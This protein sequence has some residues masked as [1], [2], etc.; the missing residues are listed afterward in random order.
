[1]CSNYQG[2]DGCDCTGGSVL[3]VCACERGYHCPVCRRDPDEDVAPEPRLL[4]EILSP[5]LM[6]SS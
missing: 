6:S 4:V 5:D 3:A 1:M 2:S